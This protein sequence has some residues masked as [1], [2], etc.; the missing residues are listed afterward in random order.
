MKVETKII[1][2][3]EMKIKKNIEITK[4]TIIIFKKIINHK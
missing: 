4:I 1:L 2:E 3:I